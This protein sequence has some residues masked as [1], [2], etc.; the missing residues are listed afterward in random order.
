MSILMFVMI[1][2][3]Y[4]DRLLISKW[5]FSEKCFMCIMVN[6]FIWMVFG[7]VVKIVS[8]SVKVIV[9][10]L[11]VILLMIIFGRFLLKILLM[12]VFS[13]GS[14]II[15]GINILVDILIF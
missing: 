3:I 4:I 12:N 14:K 13:S 5:V 1:K 9:I 10:M 6:K 11:V 15:R 2:V 8:V 7:V